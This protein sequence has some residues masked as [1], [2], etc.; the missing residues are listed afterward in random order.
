MTVSLLRRDEIIHFPAC[1]LLFSCEARASK[2]IPPACTIEE[3]TNKNLRAF[4]EPLVE[5]YTPGLDASAA[6]IQDVST[7]RITICRG[8]P[9]LIVHFR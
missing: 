9:C 4:E 2:K 5:A 6:P 1:S 7:H 8:F 3:E